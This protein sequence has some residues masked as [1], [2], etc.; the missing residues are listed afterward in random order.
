MLIEYW[1]CHFGYKLDLIPLRHQK[2]YAMT[3]NTKRHPG[4][5]NVWTQ[6]SFFNNPDTC[7][8]LWDQA[9]QNIFAIYCMREG[10]RYSRRRLWE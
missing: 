5:F 4:I 6:K 9:R 8:A 2:F 10:L 3:T 7:P 1:H